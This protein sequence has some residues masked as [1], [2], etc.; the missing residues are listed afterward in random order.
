MA[1]FSNVGPICEYVSK[2]SLF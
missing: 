1:W 2:T